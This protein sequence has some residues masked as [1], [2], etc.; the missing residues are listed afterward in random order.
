[1]PT[2]GP[3]KEQLRQVIASGD[4]SRT[5]QLVLTKDMTFGLVKFPA[6]NGNEFAVVHAAFI[7]GNGYVGP[8]AAADDKFIE[9][10]YS[11]MMGGLTAWNHDPEPASTRERQF[12]GE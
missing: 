11:D 9:G 4:D 8:S 7:G 3:T 10:A 1:M 2:L 12:V 6:G 5:N